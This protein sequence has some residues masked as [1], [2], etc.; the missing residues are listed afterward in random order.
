M[1]P[2]E[3]GLRLPCMRAQALSWVKMLHVKHLM[4]HLQLRSMLALEN[5]LTR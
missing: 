5:S 4:V 2:G 1:V 3:E